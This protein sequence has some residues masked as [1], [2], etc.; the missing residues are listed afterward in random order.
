M[1]RIGMICTLIL[2]MGLAASDAQVRALPGTQPLTWKEDLSEKMMDGAHRFVERKIDESIQTR[3]KYW[4][5]D[6][7]SHQAYENSVEP[8]RN[9]F[10]MNIGVVDARL[11]VVMERFGDDD[12]PALVAEA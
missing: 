11:P 4:K 7:S 3:Q 9:R 6:L 2:H 5:R 8:N 10:L 12:N 1:I